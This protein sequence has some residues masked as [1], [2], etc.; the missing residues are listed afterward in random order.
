MQ[1]IT[2]FDVPPDPLK[3]KS[4]IRLDPSPGQRDAIP[5]PEQEFVGIDTL[6]PAEKQGP[7]GSDVHPM[8]A[9][10]DTPAF[11]CPLDGRALDVIV[12]ERVTFSKVHP[13]DGAFT[14][15][16]WELVRA[17]ASS[18]LKVD[19][20]RFVPD[21]PGLFVL[22]L[23]LPGGWRREINVAALPPEALD[24]TVY[25]P[26][27][28]HERRMRLRAVVRSELVTRETIAAGIEG[29]TIDLATLAGYSGKKRGA[30]DVTRFRA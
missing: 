17:P 24:L 13:H 20:H 30:F 27:M 12:G 11:S 9:Q 3:S 14:G 1:P 29:P 21:V 15:A 16:A 10:F 28:G 7:R 25:P 19:D 22:A 4:N 2:P 6:F 8:L 5:A 23:T 18:R 26:S